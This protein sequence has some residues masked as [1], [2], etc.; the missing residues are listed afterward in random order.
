MKENDSLLISWGGELDMIKTQEQS[1]P[2]ISTMIDLLDSSTWPSMFLR[3]H[4]AHSRF[5][6][7][8]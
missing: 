8:L 6:E 1:D 4:I 3:K 7:A 5:Y 2:I